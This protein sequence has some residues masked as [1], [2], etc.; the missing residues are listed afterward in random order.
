MLLQVVQR[1]ALG[2][3][4]GIVEQ[5]AEEDIPLPS[6]GKLDGPHEALSATDEKHKRIITSLAPSHKSHHPSG[7]RT[8]PLAAP[9]PT[10]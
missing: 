9:K 3:V 2:P 1:I 7:G 5:V 10:R 8:L 4:I 6:V